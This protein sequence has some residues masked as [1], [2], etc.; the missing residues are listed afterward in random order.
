[1]KPFKPIILLALLS[2][3]QVAVCQEKF[4]KIKIKLPAGNAERKAVI[5]LMEADHFNAVEDGIIVE[6]SEFAQQK[7]K[8]SGYQFEV[9][10]DDVT[11]HFVAESK[12]FFEQVKSGNR[13]AFE[14]SGQRIQNFIPTPSFFSTNGL[15]PGSMGG[16]YTFSQMNTEMNDLVTAFPTLVQKTSIGTSIEGRNIW[17]LKISDNVSTDE[18]NEPEVLYL[19][20]QHAREAITGTSLIFFAQ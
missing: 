15:P 8:A 6:I 13:A 17:C 9:L 19:G 10:I 16:F 2:C 1:M 7:L 20:L 18:N 12:K 11:K 4:S 3:V 5:A 14:T